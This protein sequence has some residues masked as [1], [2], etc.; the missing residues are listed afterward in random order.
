MSKMKLEEITGLYLSAGILTREQF[1]SF[2]KT[3]VQEDSNAKDID[4]LFAE[5]RVALPLFEQTMRDIVEA[6]G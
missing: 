6:V 5:A 2:K 4:E 1:K 3:S